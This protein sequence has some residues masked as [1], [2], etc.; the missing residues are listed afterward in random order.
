MCRN[1]A[2][3]GVAGLFIKFSIK[4]LTELLHPSHIHFNLNEHETLNF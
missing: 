1:M 3:Y 4:S 2:A